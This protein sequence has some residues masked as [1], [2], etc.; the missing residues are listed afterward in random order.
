MIILK[1]ILTRFKGVSLNHLFQ[2]MA[3]LRP[4]IKLEIYPS[5]YTKYVMYIQ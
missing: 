1:W 4:G 2:D 3:K 5:G